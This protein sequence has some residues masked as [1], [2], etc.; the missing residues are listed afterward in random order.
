MSEDDDAKSKS[1]PSRAGV[2]ASTIAAIL[3]VLAGVVA[4]NWSEIQLRYHRYYFRRGT[5]KQQVEALA[6]L[7]EHRLREG[8][9]KEEVERV[10]GEPLERRFSFGEGPLPLV[11][12]GFYKNEYGRL[13]LFRDGRFWFNSEPPKPLGFRNPGRLK[14]RPSTRVPDPEKPPPPE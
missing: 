14:K 6:W 11:T 2:V 8:A 4:L 5:A 1:S 10:L 3:A 13:L 12:Y 7:C 9:T